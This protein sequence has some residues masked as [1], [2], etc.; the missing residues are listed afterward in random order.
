MH[1]LDFELRGPANKPELPVNA[2]DTQ[3][4]KIEVVTSP[5]NPW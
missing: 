4:L 5:G 2:A 3:A 1:V